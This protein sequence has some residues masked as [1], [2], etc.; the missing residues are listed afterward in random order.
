MNKIILTHKEVIKDL[1]TIVE[2]ITFPLGTVPLLLGTVP[3]PLGTVPLLLGTV[4]LLIL[5]MIDQSLEGTDY[6]GLNKGLVTAKIPLEVG[7]VFLLTIGLN[8]I[9]EQGEDHQ[10][11]GLNHQ[12]TG[13]NRDPQAEEIQMIDPQE[14]IIEIDMVM[15]DP[16]EEILKINMVI[17]MLKVYHGRLP[18]LGVCQGTE[19][20]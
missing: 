19:N 2:V 18:D 20:V 10:T 16:Q 1:I 6:Q 5:G 8:Q 7:G 4:P 12:T 15:V 17:T 11:I 13:L 3:L 9:M 14:E